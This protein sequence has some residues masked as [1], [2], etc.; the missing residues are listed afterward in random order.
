VTLKA[1]FVLTL[2]VAGAVF[3][4]VTVAV[5]AAEGSQAGTS[6]LFTISMGFTVSAVAG[7]VILPAQPKDT[8]LGN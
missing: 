8:D 7:A 5:A 4:M 3:F 6:F 1:R 2:M